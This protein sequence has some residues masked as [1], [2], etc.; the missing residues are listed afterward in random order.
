MLATAAGLVDV[1]SLVQGPSDISIIQPL[2]TS[3]FVCVIYLQ[4]VLL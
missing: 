4:S 1:V 3:S 2:L